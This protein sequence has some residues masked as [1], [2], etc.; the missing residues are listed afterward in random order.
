VQAPNG[1]NSSTALAYQGDVG[2]D[3][4]GFSMDFVGG[5]EKDAVSGSPLS[6]AQVNQLVSNQVGGTTGGAGAGVVISPLGYAIPCSL[7]CFNAVLSDNTVFSVGVKYVLGPWKFY[8][9]YEHIQFANPSTA[10]LPGAFAQGGYNLGFINANRYFTD[11]QQNVFWTGVKY[12]VT[13]TFDIIGAYYGIRQGFFEVGN[14]PGAGGNNTFFSLPGGGG[15]ASIANP[16]GGS[17]G[18]NQALACATFHA[19]SPGCAGQLDMFSLA[20]DW[21]FARH[22]DLYAGVAYTRKAGGLANGFVLTATNPNVGGT[23]NA[24]NSVSVWDPGI[25]LRYQF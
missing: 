7:G 22:L 24:S 20:M 19:S 25:G 9:G 18:T 10:L 1:G 6:T 17:F 13:P 4:L 16:A 11:R 3:Y 21:R 5:H 14:G 12:S 2:F 8:G 23:Y 15:L